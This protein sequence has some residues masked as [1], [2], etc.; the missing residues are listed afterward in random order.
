LSASDR[1]IQMG[2]PSQS[3]YEVELADPDHHE[4]QVTT[5][6]D[7]ATAAKTLSR[8]LETHQHPR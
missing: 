7:Q 8:W 1:P 2:T 5:H 6:T 4:H 3:S